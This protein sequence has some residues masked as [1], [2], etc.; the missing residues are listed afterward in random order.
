M[1]EREMKYFISLQREIILS[2]CIFYQP[3]AHPYVAPENIP[4]STQAPLILLMSVS[5]CK[6]LAFFVQKSPL[7]QSNS[8]RA[9]LDLLVLFSVFVRQKVTFTERRTFSDSASEIQPPNCS[10]LAKNL[11]NNNDVTIFRND[12]IVKFFDVFCFSCQVQLLVQVS[13]QYHH[14]FWNYDNF[15]L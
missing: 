7:T 3:F 10:K 5:F 13:R 15:L 2:W 8:V 1:H 9:V 12:V 6:K 14:W 4:F 11:K